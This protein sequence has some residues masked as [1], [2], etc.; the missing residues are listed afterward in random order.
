[1]VINS[2]C[3]VVPENGAIGE[4]VV[5]MPPST[6]THSHTMHHRSSSV[7]VADLGRLEIKSDLRSYVPD[8]RVRDAYLQIRD[9]RCVNVCL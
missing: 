1:M 6:N 3:L 5:T 2:P 9:H 7:L 8:V 4:S